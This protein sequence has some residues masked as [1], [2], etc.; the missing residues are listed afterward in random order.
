MAYTLNSTGITFN[1]GTTQSTTS[2]DRGKPISITYYTSG[3]NTYTVPAGCTKLF[4]QLQGGGGGSAGYCES[5]G[6]GGYAEGIYSVTP[7]ATYTVTIGGGGGSVGYYAAAGAGGSTS[8]GSL[9]SATGGY[10]A[11]NNYS[12]GGGIGG[13]GASGQVNLYGGSGAGHGN[14]ANHA[15]PSGGGAGFFGGPGSKTRSNDGANFGP[16]WGTGASGGITDIGS[17]GAVGTG[18]ICVIFAYT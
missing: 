17:A 10:G 18:G 9:I 14:S 3:T 12:H 8:F 13:L 5:G 11:N 16:S 1:D 2:A 6:A 4:I 15:Q 7:G